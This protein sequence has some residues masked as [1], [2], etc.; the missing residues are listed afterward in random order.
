M[1]LQAMS[2]KSLVL[3]CH[4]FNLLLVS[5]MVKNHTTQAENEPT[6]HTCL[7]YKKELGK[8]IKLLRINCSHLVTFGWTLIML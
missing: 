3:R 7:L 8:C 2:V 5:E 1:T 6:V 4:G